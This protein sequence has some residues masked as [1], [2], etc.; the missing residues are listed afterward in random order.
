[1]SEFK[2]KAIR[3]RE[4]HVKTAL[5]G[6]CISDTIELYVRKSLDTLEAGDEWREKALEI[7]KKFRGELFLNGK[8][9]RSL[10]AAIVYISGV[11]TGYTSSSPQSGKHTQVTIGDSLDLSSSSVR[12][13]YKL[14]KGPLR[15]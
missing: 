15:L 8:N 1:M 12:T 4:R 13:A 6:R 10:A 14:L 5:H 11:M 2:M 3:T 7:V 9:P